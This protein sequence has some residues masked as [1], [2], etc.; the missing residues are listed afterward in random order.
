MSLLVVGGAGFIGSHFILEWLAN[1]HELVINLDKLT[2]AGDLTFSSSLHQERKDSCYLFVQGNMNNRELVL[3]LLKKHQIRAVINFAAES[4]VDRSIENPAAFIQT[5]IVDTFCLLET[6]RIFWESLNPSAKQDFRF[7]QI[8][9]DEVYG[10]LVAQAPAFQETHCYQPNN[11]YAASKAAGDHLVRAYHQTYGFPTL[12]LHCSN[13]YGPRQFPEKLI[14]LIIHN[15]LAGKP[16][17]I[18]GDGQQLRDWIYAPDH[19]RAIRRV[20]EAGKIGETYNIGGWNERTNLTVVNIVCDLLDTLKP[21]LD[22]QSHQ[23]SIIF[24]PDRLGNDRRYAMDTSKIERE[25]GWRPRENFEMGMEK[26]VQW[27]LEHHEWLKRV[28]TNSDRG[29]A[30]GQSAL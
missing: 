16:L 1:C 6:T 8:S 28:A 26:T 15:A 10:S 5:N 24:V 18:H 7:L 12:T 14:P 3:S 25:L 29:Q 9:T 13:N 17:P 30:A 22:R 27:Y 21:R 19:C 4:H 2:Y 23:E 11:P 20:L